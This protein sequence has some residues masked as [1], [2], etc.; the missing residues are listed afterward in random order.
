MVENLPSSIIFSVISVLVYI[1]W[2]YLY[3][4]R[5]FWNALSESLDLPLASFTDEGGVYRAKGQNNARGA[6]QVKDTYETQTERPIDQMEAE[7]VDE[8]CRY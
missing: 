3:I 1:H 2:Q 4:A 7:E 6:Q 5:F 8:V